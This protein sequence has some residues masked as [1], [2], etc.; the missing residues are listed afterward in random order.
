VGQVVFDRYAG[1][2]GEVRIRDL[3]PR[4][5]VPIPEPATWL[6]LLDGLAAVLMGRCRRS[7]AGRAPGYP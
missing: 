5:F 6:L 7:R 4:N 2:L 3:L 1:A